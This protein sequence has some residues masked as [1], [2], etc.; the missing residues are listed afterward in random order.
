MSEFALFK[1]KHVLE[2]PLLANEKFLVDPPAV[3]KLRT[4]EKYWNKKNNCGVN[5][6]LFLFLMEKNPYE[7]SKKIIS[8]DFTPI[9][10]QTS[11]LGR[12]RDHRL[13]PRRDR[14]GTVFRRRTAAIEERHL[15][16][17][18]RMKT[19]VVPIEE[20]LMKNHSRGCDVMGSTLVAGSVGSY[21]WV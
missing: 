19:A 2:L 11:I 10:K 21:D 12:L 13:P 9:I 15:H 4:P 3:G 20:S 18:S 5:D 6:E 17:Y 16:L 1:T 14:V 8:Q 7:N